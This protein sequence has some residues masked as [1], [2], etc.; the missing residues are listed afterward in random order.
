MSP[1][2]E[3]KINNNNNEQQISAFSST[4][5]KLQTCRTTKYQPKTLLSTYMEYKY[6]NFSFISKP[7]VFPLTKKLISLSNYGTHEVFIVNFNLAVENR[8]GHDEINA[9][10]IS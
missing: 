1:S 2:R 5:V 7:L 4:D 6:F 3:E 8:L 9:E 10:T